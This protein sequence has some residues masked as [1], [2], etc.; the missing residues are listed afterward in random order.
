VSLIGAPEGFVARVSDTLA[1]IREALPQSPT[2]VAG[3]VPHLADRARVLES[4][5][6]VLEHADRR[7][8][9]AQGALAG[10]VTEYRPALVA[11]ELRDVLLALQSGWELRVAAKLGPTRI[12]ALRRLLAV[13]VPD[14]LELLGRV[15]DENANSNVLAWLLTPRYAP[16]VAPPA[17]QRLATLLDPPTGPPNAWPARLREAMLS[18][19]LSVRREVVFGREWADEDS[20]DRLDVLI[21]GPDFVLVI[22]NK[23]WSPEHSGQTA[24][25]WR[26]LA[27]QPVLSGGLFLSPA[28]DPPLTPGFK[29]VSYMDLLGCLLEGPASGAAL[30][31]H[32]EL[33]LASYL[34]TL[35]H[36][37]LRTELRVV[38][39]LERST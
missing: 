15:D 13:D 10:F 37:V 39:A 17:L 19:C 30:A 38:R 5:Q 9:D 14:F 22:E 18:E 33:V 16:A 29:A 4:L 28:G 27:R 20:R 34:K 11:S 21:T 3:G 36:H 7:K 6:V 12:S 23:L 31:A 1:Q 24:S 32:E 2:L 8:L 35:A 26:W 25:Y